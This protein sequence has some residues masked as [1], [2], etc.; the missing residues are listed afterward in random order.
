MTGIYGRGTR[1]ARP[2]KFPARLSARSKIHG[3]PASIRPGNPSPPNPSSINHCSNVTTAH[4]SCLNVYCPEVLHCQDVCFE[5]L[6]M[7]QILA[8]FLCI[9]TCVILGLHSSFLTRKE[10]PDIYQIIFLKTE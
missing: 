3:I 9:F 8:R 6:Y 2:H 7:A 1:P 10:C 4:Q 5:Q